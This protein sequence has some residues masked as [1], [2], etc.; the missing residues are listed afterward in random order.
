MPAPGFEPASLFVALFTFRG[1]NLSCP[2]ALI[3]PSV[4]KMQKQKDFLFQERNVT[5]LTDRKEISEKKLRLQGYRMRFFGIV[6]G[7]EGKK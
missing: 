5:E 3:I 2:V 7:F 6:C 4:S 1:R